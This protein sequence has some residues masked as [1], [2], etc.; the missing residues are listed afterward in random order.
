MSI[1]DTVLF[2]IA[3]LLAQILLA[4]LSVVVSLRTRE[5]QASHAIYIGRRLS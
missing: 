4:A 2:A 3:L 5:G 1:I